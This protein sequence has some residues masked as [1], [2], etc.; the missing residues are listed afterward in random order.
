M[1]MHPRL[2]CERAVVAGGWWLCCLP[3]TKTGNVAKERRAPIVW[4]WEIS[5]SFLIFCPLTCQKFAV[6]TCYD[7]TEALF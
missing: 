1:A 7:C 4:A 5:F 3:P 2:Q 6:S